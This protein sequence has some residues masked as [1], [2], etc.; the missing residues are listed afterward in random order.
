[1]PSS[2]LADKDVPGIEEK[3]QRIDDTLR[4]ACNY[5]GYHLAQSNMDVEL[6]DKVRTFLKKRLMFWIEAMNLLANIP[7]AYDGLQ[8]LLEVSNLLF[9]F[10]NF[11]LIS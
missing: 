10:K 3:L 9:R 7:E 4:Y 8:F 5:W 11:K 2:F 1:M 6:A